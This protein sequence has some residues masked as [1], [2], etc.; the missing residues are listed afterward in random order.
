MSTNKY[1]LK[2]ITKVFIF[3]IISVIVFNYLLV[4]PIISNE[5]ALEQMTNSNEMYL[6]T[7]TYDKIK[8]LILIVYSCVTA[9]LAGTAIYDTYKFISTKNKGEN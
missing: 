3:A 5:L 8:P 9:F 2:L 6:L 7:Q 4:S 1:I